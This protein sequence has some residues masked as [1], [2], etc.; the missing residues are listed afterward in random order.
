MTLYHVRSMFDGDSDSSVQNRVGSHSLPKVLSSA[1][2]LKNDLEGV[3]T[4]NVFACV[5]LLGISWPLN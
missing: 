4:V 3:L 1:V 2:V 5:G